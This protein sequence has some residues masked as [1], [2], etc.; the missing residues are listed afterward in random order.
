MQVNFQIL[1][2]LIT[3]HCPQRESREEDPNQLRDSLCTLFS[4]GLALFQLW[5][6]FFSAAMESRRR[7]PCVQ[8]S[9]SLWFLHSNSTTPRVAVF[10]PKYRRCSPP[11]NKCLP[12][13]GLT[14]LHTSNTTSATR[15]DKKKNH[16]VR[17]TESNKIAVT[18]VQLHMHRL[19]L[20]NS[21][22]IQARDEKEGISVLLLLSFLVIVPATRL[23]FIFSITYKFR[24]S[25]KIKNPL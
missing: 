15:K 21:Q 1:K 8:I 12:G 20:F 10:N 9:C 7:T 5:R 25:C 11:S 2:S 22:F 14:S 4:S 19:G 18:L 3:R 6:L 16:A 23:L 13:H 24:N 17:L